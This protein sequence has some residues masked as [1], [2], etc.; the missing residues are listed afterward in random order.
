VRE[1]EFVFCE[2]MGL[3]DIIDMVLKILFFCT[4]VTTKILRIFHQ[5][6]PQKRRRRHLSK[7]KL[8]LRRTRI[9]KDFDRTLS[10]FEK[11]C[12]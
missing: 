5:H 1:R 3:D 4:K 6:L 9:L 12:K 7:A 2:T 10:C 8:S 11:E